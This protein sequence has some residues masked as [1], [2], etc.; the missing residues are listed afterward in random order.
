[1][2]TVFLD[3][4]GVINRKQPDD[5]YVKTWEEF[6][7]LP[8]AQEALLLLR[9]AGMRLVVVTNQRGVARGRLTES[10]LQHIHARMQAELTAAGVVLDGIYY[11]PHDKGACDCRK[12]LPGLFRQARRD[13]PDIVFADS[14]VVGDSL[15]DLEAGASLGCRTVLIAEGSR[16][17]DILRAAADQGIA[18]SGVAS[19]LLEAAKHGVLLEFPPLA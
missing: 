2:K 3:R 15:S 11:C 10:A 8:R 18:V 14:A 4:D 6:E 5:D 19:S 16:R 17:D 9:R 12:P 7:F 1:M 13:F